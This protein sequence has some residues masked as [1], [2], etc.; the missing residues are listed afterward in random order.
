MPTMMLHPVKGVKKTEDE[1]K[2]E[3]EV[4]EGIAKAAAEAAEVAAAGGGPLAAPPPGA[5][6]A[7][8]AAHP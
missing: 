7:P 3:A 1:L 4:K 8:G 2:E 5:P 6:G